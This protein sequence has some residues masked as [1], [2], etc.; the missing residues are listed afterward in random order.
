[1]IKDFKFKNISLDCIFDNTINNLSFET[2]VPFSK[3]INFLKKNI[4]NFTNFAVTIGNNYGFIR[5]SIAKQ[6]IKLGLS[7]LS[8]ISQYS[9]IEKSSE[10][11]DGSLIMPGAVVNKF[12]NIGSQCILN[13]N[14][15]VDHECVIGHG[16]H[17]MPGST[18]TGR[19]KIGDFSTIGS[20]STILPDVKIGSNVFVGAGSVVTKNL[21]DNQIVVGAPAKLLKKIHNRHK[22]NFFK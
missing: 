22:F 17:V 2:N 11:G 6:L 10:I 14:S 18:I 21:S 9:I 1:M 13:T 12:C 3:D 19:V 7:P 15:S 4:K 8:F 16:V 5:F 20:N